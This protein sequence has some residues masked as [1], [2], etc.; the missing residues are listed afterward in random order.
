[1]N[2]ISIFDNDDLLSKA[3]ADFI[4]SLS[5]KA[6]AERGRFTIALSGGSTPSKLFALMAEPPYS[7]EMNWKQTF[8]FWGDERYVPL[9]DERNNSHIAKKL[10]LSNV[11]IPAE[12]IFVVPVKMPPAKAAQHYE[13]TIRIFFKEELPVFDLILLGMGD[14]G[15]TAS[16]FPHTAIIDEKNA[17]VKDV[18][19]EEVQ[20]QRI[21]FTAPLINHA[22]N[23][24]FLVAGKAKA[25]MLKKVL[26]GEK[27][28]QQ[29]P[30]QMIK[31]SKG[32][33]LYWF[34]DK[35]AAEKLKKS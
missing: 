14:N 15:H 33:H 19:V 18:Y 34:L 30:A 29:Y 24:V 3:A 7:S 31:A 11:H 21:S 12:N 17:L 4:F 9:D 35:A 2:K 16:L 23:I 1:M 20:M 22:K 32:N 26:E 8:V 28:I 6:I 25:A 5:Q 27:N 13:K 10:L